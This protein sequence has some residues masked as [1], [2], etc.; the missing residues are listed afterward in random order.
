MALHENIIELLRKSDIFSQLREY[1]LDIIARHSEF[2][3]FTKAQIVFSHGSSAD[4]LYIV[5]K[6][7]I[8]IICVEDEDDVK[9]AQIV[10][11]ESFGELDFLGRASR[12]A[13]A[14][15]EEDS[16][17]LRFP[18]RGQKADEIFMKHAYI[19]AVMLYRLL[20]IVS[21]RIWRVN[22]LLYEKTNWL[23]DLH[24]Q[25]SFDKMTG[26]FNQSFIREDFINLIPDLGNQ[27]AIIMIKPDNFK[28]IND[29]YGHEAG[30]RV[31]NLM[32]I[33]LQSELKESD[34]GIRYRGDEFAAILAN[35]GKE[36]AIRRAREISHTYKAIDLTGLIESCTIKIE[37]SI[38][39]ALFPRDSRNSKALVEIAH[40]KML[41]A[42][43]LGGDTIIL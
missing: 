4:E 30:D 15:A 41:H 7:R 17:L 5:D 27:A 18:A 24:K 23:R 22:D 38:G 34:I 43:E 29:Q 32:A 14:F 37:V 19:S 36:E 12:N 35:A 31:L 33:F 28:D 25:L 26:L 2:I 39:I 20:G 10:S 1:E 3:R 11:G 13:A 6:G 21:E 8:G 40:K 9:I 42:R 16:I